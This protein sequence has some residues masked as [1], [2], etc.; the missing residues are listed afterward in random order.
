M[1]TA[2]QTVTQTCAVEL[3]RAALVA[4][5]DRAKRVVP[6]R[7][8]KPILMCVHLEASE[9][10]LRLQ[11][12]DGELSLFAQILVDG[13]LP[14]CVVPLAELSRRLKASKH[15][16]CSLSLSDD[17]ERLLINGGRVEHALQTYDPAEFPLVPS[18]L[19]GDSIE[20][21]A[22]ELVHAV[23]VASHAVA[24]EPSRYAIDGIL[25]E[26]NEKGS[27]LVATDGRR[28]VMVE[29]PNAGELDDQALMPHRLCRLIDKLT[30]RDTDFLALAVHRKKDENGDTLPGRI[31]AAGPDWVLSTYECDGRF[32]IYR[33]I[34]PR[35]HSKF[36]ILERTQ[37][38][39]SRP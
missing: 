26:S 7:F 28:L 33:D 27:R 6:V 32:P 37:L 1:L 11:A 36:A 13:S 16:T 4:L 5:L 9:G 23:K 25:L 8:P 10:L 15:P 24:K 3:S 17:G 22:A 19:E 2:E 14:A 18:Q 12:T 29:L 21:D 30:T 31:F 20:V 35:S 34:V 39:W 38:R